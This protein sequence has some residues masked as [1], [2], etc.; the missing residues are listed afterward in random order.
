[1]W[2]K[3]LDTTIQIDAIEAYFHKQ[4]FI[5]LYKMVVTFLAYWMR[6]HS[7]SNESYRA[8]VLRFTTMYKVVTTTTTTTLFS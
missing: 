2:I 7:W 6:G 8:V 1:M 5:K 3:A 4:L